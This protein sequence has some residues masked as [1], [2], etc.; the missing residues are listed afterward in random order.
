MKRKKRY[1]EWDAKGGFNVKWYG[2]I[3]ISVAKTMSDVS[4]A[5]AL[6]VE[7]GSPITSK[8]LKKRSATTSPMDITGGWNWKRTK[9]SS[10]SH[11]AGPA[12]EAQVEG[13]QA[14]DEDSKELLVEYGQKETSVNRGTIDPNQP[15]TSV[16]IYFR[17]IVVVWM[18][19]IIRQ[20]HTSIG[21]W[22]SLSLL[23]YFYKKQNV[24]SLL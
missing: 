9:S 6:G 4:M 23:F 11:L 14:M 1:E 13:Q 19:V 24:A 2:E 3:G 8:L 21:C 22:H 15:P 18:Q 5:R 12:A 20:F 17:G 10:P 16:W 7:P